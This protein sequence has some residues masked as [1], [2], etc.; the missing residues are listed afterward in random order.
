MSFWSATL[1]GGSKY[2]A[3]VGAVSVATTA[4]FGTSVAVADAAVAS[5][6]ADYVAVFLDRQSRRQLQERFGTAHKMSMCDHATL[7]FSPSPE[8][9]HVYA[10]LCGSHATVRALGYAEDEH[11]QAVLVDVRSQAGGAIRSANKHPHVTL[12]AAGDGNYTAKYSNVLLE[13]LNEAGALR[14]EAGREWTGELPAHSSGGIDYASSRA[15][16]YALDP[17]LKL[18]GI[19]CTNERYDRSKVAEDEGAACLCEGIEKADGGDAADAGAGAGTKE[20]SDNSDGGGEAE[21]GGEKKEC[22]FC[23]WMRAG[24]CGDQFRDWEKCLDHCKANDMD[25]VEHCGPPTL[26]LKDCV[27]SNPDY[28]AEL[29]NDGDDTADGANDGA[30]GAESDSHEDSKASSHSSDSEGTET[31]VETET[32]TV[33]AAAQS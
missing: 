15:K 30:R 11:G 16:Y 1:R 3:A 4:G 20:D 22:G 18:S 28:Y 25:F 17:P 2:A 23:L 32:K 5:E 27:D 12:S 9:L 29:S 26:A 31:E 8:Q 13:R 21:G 14:H 10:P 24:P 7:R 19:V 6:P 33:T